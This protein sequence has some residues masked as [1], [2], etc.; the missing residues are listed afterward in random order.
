MRTKII[1]DAC[2]NHLG[3]KRLI[4]QMIIKAAEAGVDIIKFQSFKADNLNKDYP[5]FDKWYNYYK[6]VQLEDSDYELILKTCDRNGIEPLFTAFTMESIDLLKS[7]GQTSVKI[8]SPSAEDFSLVT[9]CISSFRKI[10]MSTGMHD[11]C[12]HSIEDNLLRARDS[13]GRENIDP[14][15]QVIFFYCISKYPAPKKEVDKFEMHMFPGFSDHTIDLEWS[16]K[17]IDFNV[18]YV[19][20][21]YTLGKDLPGKDHTYSSTPEEFK[22]LVD[23]ATYKDKCEWY[24]RRWIG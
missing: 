7:L 14:K 18:Q 10:Y 16:K 12:V 19:E 15:I 22:E 17:A 5:D 1:A 23:Y 9:K 24:K 20:R 21:H 11:G 4:E 8:A 6:A 2:C 3:D 13:A